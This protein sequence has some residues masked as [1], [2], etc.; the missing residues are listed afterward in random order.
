MKFII[1]L[2]NI[3]LA[4]LIFYELIKKINTITETLDDS[5]SKNMEG[6]VY[7]QEAKLD[8]LTSKLK[9]VDNGLIIMNNNLKD[10]KKKIQKNSM[11]LKASS[12]MVKN[13]ANAKMKKLDNM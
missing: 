6:A 11:D 1:V 2:T 5:C 3:F 8:K 7:Q 13:E 9:D 10:N 12:N 4:T